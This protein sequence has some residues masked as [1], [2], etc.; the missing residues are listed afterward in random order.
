MTSRSYSRSLRSCG[1]ENGMHA[2]RWNVPQHS[3]L[4]SHTRYHNHTT[5]VYQYTS[6]HRV[7]RPT[8]PLD[9]LLGLYLPGY[10]DAPYNYTADGDGQLSLTS[11]SVRYDC[12]IRVIVHLPN[13]TASLLLYSAQCIRFYAGAWSSVNG[14]CI[15]YRYYTTVQW[16]LAGLNESRNE[17][18]TKST[19]LRIS[20]RAMLLLWYTLKC[21]YPTR[22]TVWV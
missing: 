16:S 4:Y 22:P 9:Y 2:V 14:Q 17:I 1:S 8:C 20:R 10:R 18:P 12:N 13:P 11:R 6:Q 3:H 15:E 19:I 5:P 21:G 7:N